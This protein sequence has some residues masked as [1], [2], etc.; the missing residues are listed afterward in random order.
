MRH[1]ILSALGEMFRGGTRYRAWIACLVVL[2][3]FGAWG[4]RRQLQEGLVVT[5]LSDQVSWGLYI[6]NFAFMVGI[7]AS[8]VLLVIPA[9]L[10]H[11]GDFRR[12]VILGEGM[13]VAAVSMALLFVLVDLG[14][15]DRIW[16]GIPL[17]GRL[18]FPASLLAWDVIVLMGYL[19]LN[20]ATPFY[21]LYRRF[22]GRGP[23]PSVYF[24]F[25]VL[26][27]VWAIA[28]HTVTAFVFSA[29]PARP[30][31]HHAALAPHFIVTAFA[32]GPALIIL[33]LRAI[34]R[35]TDFRVG[36]G[37]ITTLGRI[38]TVTMQINLFF[39]G[40]GLFTDFYHEGTHAL[41]ARYLYFGLNGL[42]ALRGW[43]W[44]A[45]VMNGV[46]T[47]ILTLH[48]LRR[49]RW[50][51]DIACVLGVLGI[52]MEKGL[53]LVVPGFIPTP[54]GEVFE[55]TPTFIEVA[56]STGILAFGILIF[57]LLTKAAIGIEAGR[58]RR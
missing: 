25:I 45:I 9:Y 34:R 10:F 42:D 20:I 47:A 41:S 6:G 31:W 36:D 21:V 17:L 52:W 30:F 43:I 32:S 28:L 5:G 8:A 16:H 23:N 27:I 22:E 46:A 53:G 1:F 38:L 19:L 50:F 54:L 37:V 15:P 12:V 18:N 35:L 24:P 13:A 57:T 14:R 29:N 33:A 55:Y 49:R 11:R 58:A 26:A 39:I 40:V 4:Y 3:L 44:A 2:F 48:P 51:L 7:A 56:V